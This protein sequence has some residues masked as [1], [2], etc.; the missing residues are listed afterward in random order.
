MQHDRK[1]IYL[2]G[3]LFS[4]PAALTSYINSSFLSTLTSEKSVSLIYALGSIVSIATLLAA[5]PIWRRIGGYKFLLLIALADALSLLALSLVKNAWSIF[6]IFVLF[7]SFNILIVF[8]LDELLK[9]FSKD[10]ATGKV[11]G[12]YLAL[13]HLAWITTQLAYGTILGEFPFRTIYFLGFAAMTL[14]LLTAHFNLKNIPDPKYDKMN[15]VKYTKEFFKNK[16]LFRA[17]GL[18]FL[19]QFFYCW[20]V[21]YTPIYLY[22]HLGF[23]WREIGFIFAIMLLPF[24]II[25][26]PLG[27]YADKIG[28]RKI[29]MFGF[30]I[31][32]L[33]TLS[34]FFIPGHKIFIWALFLFL[35]RVGAASIEVASDAYFF[36]HIKPENEEFVGVYRS[37]PPVAYVLGPL[38]AFAMFLFVPSF[39]F[40][41]V[42]LGAL[43]LSGVYLSSTIKKGDV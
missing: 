16:N 13:C 29:L 12:T 17:Y 11:R 42:I 39:N 22:L 15:T 10:S 37:A 43:M 25:P 20:M 32:S 38:F 8:S 9:I 33:A 2:A 28:E 18:N 6:I 36:K 21:I 34:L 27:K 5:P 7:L 30:A 41:Y 19:L 31:I 26:F 40:I 23:S 1:I 3:F 35:T 14:F 4:I 24:L